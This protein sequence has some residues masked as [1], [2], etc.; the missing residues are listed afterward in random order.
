MTSS[1]LLKIYL[2]VAQVM[3]AN[4]GSSQLGFPFIQATYYPT[5]YGNTPAAVNSFNV[6]SDG[7][8]TPVQTKQSQVTYQTAEEFN[9]YKKQM[10]Q[11]E[12]DQLK[13]RLN[14]LEKK[15]DG[16]SK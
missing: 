8:S 5:T 12:L 15:I 1:G 6:T 3:G 11:T 2:I 7:T 4:I 16:S 14:A 10:Y 13:A 9:S